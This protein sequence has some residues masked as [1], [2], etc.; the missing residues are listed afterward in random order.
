MLSGSHQERRE[1]QRS[2][3]PSSTTATRTTPSTPTRTTA[4]TTL[5]G[6]TGSIPG[7]YELA[8]TG[9]QHIADDESTPVFSRRDM[10][11]E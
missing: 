7:G 1:G 9:P 8:A 4:S 3:P 6:P 10:A 11:L 5:S 2:T